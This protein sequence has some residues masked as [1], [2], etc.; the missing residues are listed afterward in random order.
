MNGGRKYR[1]APLFC[2]Q[3]ITFWL[4]RGIVERTP[5]LLLV[6]YY[7]SMMSAGPFAANAGTI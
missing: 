1:P 7:P 4:E 3:C 2:Y 6:L 5:L